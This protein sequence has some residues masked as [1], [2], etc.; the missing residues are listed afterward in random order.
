RHDREQDPSSVPSLH[1][2]LRSV[3]GTPLSRR[4]RATT[5]RRLKDFAVPLPTWAGMRSLSQEVWMIDRQQSKL[6]VSAASAA[7][8]LFL[9]LAFGPQ[10][11]AATGFDQ[12]QNE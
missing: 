2:G 4:S 6:L 12:K 7:A 1:R 8:V 3:L 5:I 11:H 9:G 10:L